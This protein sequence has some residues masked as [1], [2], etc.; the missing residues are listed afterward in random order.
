VAGGAPPTFT[1]LAPQAAAH[2]ATGDL[3][4][5]VGYQV[6]FTKPMNEA[7]VQNA[8]T[9]TPQINVK[10]LWDATSQVLSLVPDPH[11]EPPHSVHGGCQRG[12]F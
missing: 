9:I 6:Q 8:L 2:R 11:W 5:D 3:A 12:S 7:S 1:A 4:L 10:Y